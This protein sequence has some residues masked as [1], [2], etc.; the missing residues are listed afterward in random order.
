MFFVM[1]L[2]P[3][4]ENPCDSDNGGCSHLCLLSATSLGH[5]SCACPTGYKI[6]RSKKNCLRKS[7][8]P[9]ALL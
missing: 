3:P 5:S 2:L 1:I 9:S 7:Q 6:D 4:V 8:N